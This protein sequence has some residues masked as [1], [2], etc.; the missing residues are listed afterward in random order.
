MTPYYFG[1]VAALYKLGLHPTTVM[2]AIDRR[3]RDIFRRGSPK[4]SENFND[5]LERYRSY[6]ASPT[7]QKFLKAY[8]ASKYYGHDWLSPRETLSG[9]PAG[10]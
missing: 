3:A 1:K 9:F 6:T 8:D 2:N 5:M 4:K 10:F 7:A